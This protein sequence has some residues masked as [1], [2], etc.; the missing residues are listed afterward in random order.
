[1]IIER[2]RNLAPLLLC[3]IVLGLTLMISPCQNASAEMLETPSIMSVTLSSGTSLT[4]TWSAVPSATGYEVYRSNAASGPYSMVTSTTSTSFTNTSLSTGAVYYY[5]V[6][7]YEELDFNLS[8]G[9]FSASKAGVPL[10]APVIKKIET[11]SGTSLKI[12]WGST[13]GASGYAL[14]RSTSKTGTYKQVYSGAST[15]YTNSG[16]TSGTVYYYKLKSIKT[17]DSVKFFS[18]FGTPKIGVPLMAPQITSAAGVGGTSVKV[19]WKPVTGATSYILYRSTS[20]T[21]TYKQVYSGASTAFTNSG[22]TSGTVYY[23]KLKSVRTINSVKYYSNFGTQKAVAPLMTPQITSVVG[24]G[25]NSVKVEWQPVTGATSY[26]L[27]RSTSKTGSYSQVYI[28]PAKSF[29]NSSLINGRVYFYKV[30]ALKQHYTLKFY[31]GLGLPKSGSPIAVPKITS[32]VFD[33]VSSAT[34]TWSTVSD[35][36]GYSLY[37]STNIDGPYKLIATTASTTFT[38]R[39]LNTFT[40]YFYKVNAFKRINTIKF[41]SNFSPIK[42][43]TTL[44][45]GEVG[46]IMPSLPLNVMVYGYNY[47]YGVTFSRI[48]FETTD[49]GST[50]IYFTGTKNVDSKG[51]YYD[52]T[53]FIDYKL[54]NAS[55]AVVDSGTIM[56]PSVDLGE[57][58]Y[59]VR[60]IIFNLKPGLYYLDIPSNF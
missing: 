42:N 6:R 56:T 20:K 17:V 30:K 52:R 5:K 23:Y 1:M 27:Y 13:L 41:S 38:N 46:I 49:W 16:L 40:K 34:I 59:D 29:T 43:F 51:Y 15:T 54:Y 47:Y 48:R 33:K 45:P 50:Y 26:I 10:A 12:S 25:G 32:I 39:S 4:V 11:V 21:G 60:E 9:D 14:F 3:A 28:G 24:A 37:R 58:F 2:K 8:Y 36:A 44:I 22:L 57:T 18:S 35:A 55:G 31:S 19:T 53:C 7:A